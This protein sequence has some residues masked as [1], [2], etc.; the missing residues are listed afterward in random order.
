[1]TWTTPFTAS[2]ND[3]LPSST[4]N[5]SVRDDLFQTEAFVDNAP[6]AHYIAAGANV[7]MIEGIQSSRVATLETTTSTAYVDLS[8][9]GPTV[10]VALHS[11]AI[12]IASAELS[13]SST[14]SASKVSVAMS[15]SSTIAASDDWSCITD[16]MNAFMQSRRG[17]A[18]RFTG[19]SGACT[20]T[21]KYAA[22]SGVGS[23]LNR[24]LIV[25]PF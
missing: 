21:M 11:S 19:I 8:T 13:N 17:V 1:M 16:G 5:A 7:I 25:I 10:T 23:F 6:G 4:W 2:L 18:H 22:S 3:D 12:V 24:E 9:V 15:G 20:F 14:N